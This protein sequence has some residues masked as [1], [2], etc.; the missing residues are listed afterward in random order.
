MKIVDEIYAMYRHHLRGDEED[1]LALIMGLFL[2]HNRQDLLT[3]IEEMTKE[4]LLQMV[5][6]Y[7]YQLLRLKMER[8]GA[9]DK[10]GNEPV[11]RRFH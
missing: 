8:E 11:C 6:L 3:L 1:L 5:A 7:T 4:E 9:D 2:D 10:S